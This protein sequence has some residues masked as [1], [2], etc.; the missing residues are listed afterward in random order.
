MQLPPEAFDFKEIEISRERDNIFVGLFTKNL[1][2]KMT[3]EIQKEYERLSKKYKLPKF[4]DIDLVFEISTIEQTAFLL[5]NIIGKIAEK[6]EFYR[7]FLEEFLQPDTSSISGMH[8]IR[9]FL[10]DEKQEIYSLYKKLMKFN[11]ES[12][13]TDLTQDEKLEAKY[14][15]NIFNA[16]AE[17]KKDLLKYTEKMKESWEKET[18]T[19]EELPYFG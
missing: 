16:W 9:F 6:I 15:Y 18:V 13:E 4:K 3:N 14:I 2:T 7:K 8:E 19:D 12:I 17:T 1:L 10:D 5:R 11:R